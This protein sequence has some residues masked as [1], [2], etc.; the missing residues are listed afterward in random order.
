VDN[1][2][3][4]QR[5]NSSS[6]ERNPVEV[7]AEEFLERQR[8]GERPTLR[9]YTEKYPDLAEDIRDLFPALIKMEQIRP[10]DGDATGPSHVAN[11]S[12]S[13]RLE[14]LGDYRIL[15]EVGRG[16]MGI[17]YEAEQ[18]SLGRHVALKVLASHH[19]LDARQLQR[20]QRES[21]A[22]ARLHHTNIVPVFGVGEA[23][24]LHY[25]VMQFIQGLGLDEVLSE[26]RRIKA[27]GQPFAPASPAPAATG[28]SEASARLVAQGLLTGDFGNQV[29]PAES[30]TPLPAGSSSNIHLPGQ[31][32]GSTLSEAGRQ[33]W[34]SVARVGIQVAE[35]LGYASS[36]GVL[37]RDVKPS[38]L[39]LDGRGTVW[40]TDFGLAKAADAEDLTHT[41]D[42]VGTLRYL[43][44]ER[45]QGKSDLR[46]DLYALGLTLYE[47]LTLR[48][49]FD[50]SDRAR[51]IQQVTSTEPPPPRK[52]NPAVPRDLETVVLKAI[53][54]S[55]EHRYQTAAEMAADLQRFV[56]DRPIL[57]RRV[58]VRERFYR[59]C[60]RN[61]LLASATGLAAAALVAVTAVSLVFARAQARFAAAQEQTNQQQEITNKELEKTLESLSRESATLA[62]ERSRAL[63]DKNEIRPAMLWLARGLERVPAK[64]RELRHS[65]RNHLV[66]LHYHLP[67]LV[68]ILPRQAGLT[69]VAFGG[70]G[71]IIYTVAGNERT[72]EV[73][74]WDAATGKLLGQPVR[75]GEE[76]S[77]VNLPAVARG[78][79][80]NASTF[81]P[82]LWFTFHPHASTF[83]VWRAQVVTGK[84]APAKKPDPNEPALRK[85]ETEIQR[86]DAGRGKRLGGSLRL[87][88][89]VTEVFWSPNGKSFWTQS[90][91]TLL[92]LGTPPID[93]AA[94][95]AALRKLK[96]R[97]QGW[98]ASTFQALGRQYAFSGSSVALIAISPDGTK[99]LTMDRLSFATDAGPGRRGVELRLCDLGAGKETILET[100]D[101]TPVQAYS[102]AAFSHDGKTIR[103]LGMSMR[104]QASTPQSYQSYQWDAATGKPLGK[105]A[106]LDEGIR[107]RAAVLR[108]GRVGAGFPLATL[109]AQL[110]VSAQF[111][112]GGETLLV[113]TSNLRE[114]RVVNATTG[115]A[116]MTVLV[117]P[118]AISDL[119]FSPDGS[120][121]LIAGEDGQGNHGDVRL[122]RLPTANQLQPLFPYLAPSLGQPLGSRRA[123]STSRY[124]HLSPDG[125]QFLTLRQGRVQVWELH[126]GKPVGPPLPLKTQ[127]VRAD[128]SGDGN[129]VFT[130]AGVV[131]S[132]GHFSLQLW[133]ARTGRAAGPPIVCECS[134]SPLRRGQGGPGSHAAP[135]ESTF[136][137]LQSAPVVELSPD[138]RT[139][140]CG[141]PNA[142]LWDA[143]TG[144]V[145]GAP[146]A[147]D[148]QVTLVAFAPNGKTAL[149]VSETNRDTSPVR[150]GP[151]DLQLWHVPTRKPIGKPRRFPSTVRVATFAPDGKTFVTLTGFGALPGSSIGRARLWD[152]HTGGALGQALPH[153]DGVTFVLYSPDSRLVL[154]GG[155]RE[156]QL[157][158]V[159]SGKPHGEP[160]GHGNP[161]RVAAFSPDGRVLMTECAQ[162]IQRWWDVRTG[163]QIGLPITGISSAAGLA[164]SRDG[165]VI[166]TDCLQGS[167]RFHDNVNPIPEE[168]GAAVAWVEATLGMRLTAEGAVQGLDAV[169]WRSRQEEA[170]RAAPAPPADR[171]FLRLHSR[172]ATFALRNADP[173][174]AKWHLDHQ[175]KQNPGD[176][177]ALILRAR[178]HV[179]LAQLTEAQADFRAAL[180]ASPAL[181]L[182]WFNAFAQETPRPAK[183]DNR[184]MVWFLK[185][186][187]SL[188][189]NNATVVRQFARQLWMN[190]AY[191]E[192]IRA[193]TQI[194][195][196]DP[197]DHWSWFQGGVLFL[198]AGD[199][200]GHR[201]WCEAMLKRFADTAD[202]MLMERTAKVCL[203]SPRPPGDAAL[204]TRLVDG[205]LKKGSEHVY[206]KYFQTA[207][208]LA[209]LRASKY[210]SAVDWLRKSLVNRRSLQDAVTLCFLAIAEGKNGNRAAAQKALDE[211]K[212]SYPKTSRILDIDDFVFQLVCR[213]A[214]ELL[215]DKK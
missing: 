109:P 48:P 130:V 2:S 122:W 11:G 206:F 35:A 104:N 113:G 94:R 129:L 126:T 200:A 118:G 181:A 89:N 70:G 19:L 161:V 44:P 185:Q 146:L 42:V 106:V 172:N 6:D 165:T 205:A 60:R 33:Y 22:A 142:Q 198:R 133:D 83:L 182:V 186:L 49:A 51:L 57:A 187:V 150:V 168:P 16:G 125:K 91:E 1:R 78:T 208:G 32:E 68:T 100:P 77:D 18:E 204:L 117:H 155:V 191:G 171:R 108:R 179:E 75:V 166:L 87:P 39:L 40:V 143:V 176:A 31:A 25:Y 162:T 124:A 132:P 8:R 201:R 139:L 86:W 5:M 50:E 38:N 189:G 10:Q 76:F 119:E 144:R 127:A 21:K 147:R 13:H 183:K 90:R 174:A 151:Q 14:R 69:D 28:G 175:L 170:R 95:A 195:A 163:T 212:A 149:T 97:Y 141:G 65:L 128:F 173:F 98:D 111:S 47:M 101:S 136:P 110:P 164:F 82:R 3:E 46:G 105:A 169:T 84:D 20:F 184:A 74:R 92:P 194:V 85:M 52:V 99:L 131:K 62:I 27:A 93:A 156:A 9:E 67:E 138:G 58:S 80:P 112:S 214:E 190:R 4:T 209:E 43:A 114:A 148:G 56:D 193:Y 140:L 36:Q 213:E 66:A 134:K 107:A 63:L 196:L 54:R 96:T 152:A 23:N 115:K 79:T 15:R 137:W 26:L 197:D 71:R 135:G 207:K 59:W 30:E 123:S 203:L 17:V 154:T 12:G 167:P 210:A 81:R 180:A 64:D 211:A 202:P 153:P 177:L 88:M 24:G 157:W 37:H 73:R 61:P 45:F 41:G 188:E 178:A 7:L 159:P 53:A 72:T 199:H 145:L 55:P 158:E 102:C 160:M 34:Q 215:A 120:Q 103:A 116:E 121:V 192:A 29:P